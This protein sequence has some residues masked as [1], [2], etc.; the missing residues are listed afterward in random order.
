MPSFAS[1]TARQNADV[2][3]PAY[4]WKMGTD[5][6]ADYFARR[7][8]SGSTPSLRLDARLL[9]ELA[10][11]LHLLRRELVELFRRAMRGLDADSDQAVR[12]LG[13]LEHPPDVGVQLVD[14]RPRQL[15]RP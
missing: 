9:G 7:S 4:S 14:D 3:R 15:H 13:H 12:H 6:Q 10:C 1:S 5:L 11:F 2:R 8:V